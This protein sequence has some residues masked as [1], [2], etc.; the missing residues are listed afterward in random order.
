MC[1]C[2]FPGEGGDQLR[3]ALWLVDRHERADDGGETL[4]QVGASVA[5]F[6]DALRSRE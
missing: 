2:R 1:P 6:L 5:R 3:G 4:E